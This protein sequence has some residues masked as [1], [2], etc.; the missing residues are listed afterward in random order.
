[1]ANELVIEERG[2]IA[3]MTINRPEKLNAWSSDV[4]EQLKEYLSSLNE[5]EY[6]KRCLILTG[7]G[8][9]FCSGAD[10]SFL[11]DQTDDRQIP[12]R[13]PRADAHAAELMRR[14]DV[15]IIGAINGYAVGAGFGIAL[16]TDMRIAAD[17]ARFQVTQ[18]KRGVFADGGLGHLLP[19]AVGDQRA[20]EIMSTARWIDAE[21]ALSL[22]LVLRVVPRDQL[23]DAALELAEQVALQSP[24]SLAASKRV[25]YQRTDAAWQRSEEFTYLVI[26]RMF[27]TED[28]KEG[29]KS[30][31]E[32]REPEFKGC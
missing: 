29:V 13:L 18:M 32:R 11:N 3:I 4:T 8:R 17:D 27:L 22:G 26:D 23:M 16:G 30:F 31:V 6:S 7:E 1:V 19:Q 14:C 28:A 5:G 20:F 24:I 25:I 21:E 10:I 15:P 2:P 9:A 12:W